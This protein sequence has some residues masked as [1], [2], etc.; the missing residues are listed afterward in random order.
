MHVNV[1]EERQFIDLQ[2]E[3]VC[4]GSGDTPRSAAG[5]LTTRKW[6]ILQVGEALKFRIGGEQDLPTQLDRAIGS[7]SRIVEGEANQLPV[8]QSVVGHAGGDMGVM[9]L[10]RD[11]PG[12]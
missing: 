4:I 12:R 7:V 10:H 3:R 2:A 1:L 11:A 8:I 5:S 9:M 6:Q